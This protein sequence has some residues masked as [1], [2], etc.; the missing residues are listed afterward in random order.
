[1]VPS[2]PFFSAALCGSG[3]LA[4][5]PLQIQPIVPGGRIQLDRY[6]DPGLNISDPLHQIVRV[7]NEIATGTATLLPNCRVITALH[8]LLG[9]K[10]GKG[11]VFLK[12]GQ[13]VIGDTFEY[14]TKPL[15][16]LGGQKAIGR[17]V[18]LGHGLHDGGL[19]FLSAREDWAVGY[20]AECLSKKLNLGEV[21]ISFRLDWPLL[22]NRE[23]MHFFTAGYSA[24]AGSNIQTKAF[25]LYV[26]SRCHISNDH[27]DAHRDFSSY[28]WATTN[29][30]VYHGGSGQ[31]L[32]RVLEREG[33]A[34]TGADGR[35]RLLAYGLFQS[36]SNEVVRTLELVDGQRPMGL[37]T[38]DE[39]FY[40][41]L[42]PA[43][44]CLSWM[45]R[46]ILRVQ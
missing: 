8:V 11:K 7:R 32:L 23:L 36:A 24:I 33:Q 35:P 13:L 12:P 10:Y 31:L 15:P 25:P 16:A 43:V 2:R 5:A 18:V 38:F 42:L 30:S 41:R 21:T 19:P 6:S 44:C 22:I 26:D 14:E 9:I 46:W 40:S 20:D 45:G 4:Q 17:F 29:C 27:D 39:S 1:M 37:A 3:P 34:V 28:S